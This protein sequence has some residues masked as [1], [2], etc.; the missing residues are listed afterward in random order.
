MQGLKAAQVLRV[1]QKKDEG[2]AKRGLPISRARVLFI[3]FAVAVSGLLAHGQE[4]PSAPGADSPV[5]EGST[6][7]KG[8]FRDLVLPTEKRPLV[9]LTE[10]D[11]LFKKKSPFYFSFFNWTTV[12]VQDYREGDG[13]FSSYNFVSIDYRLNYDSKISFRPV[14]FLSSS[15]KNFFGKMVEED[16]SMG[17]AYFQYFHYNLALLPGGVGLIG[18]LRLYVPLSENS[19]KNKMFTRTQLRLLFTKPLARGWELAYHI[20]PSYYFYAQ[21]G[22]TN[23]FGGAKGNKQGEVEHFFELNERL[24]PRFGLSQRVGITHDWKYD[25]PS[26]NVKAKRDEYLNL[27]LMASYS[28]GLANFRVGVINDIKLREF[29]TP[30][31]RAYKK[32]FALFREEEMQYSLMTYMRF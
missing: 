25:V 29:N 9:P 18:A 10:Q 8:V 21:R 7:T 32:P 4:P 23:Y 13:Q 27:S 3:V 26:Q 14:F 6:S 20:Y 16:L 17:D 28:L 30:S 22:T 19:K 15:G 12:N 31:S 5:G 2:N 11:T 24:T 1:F